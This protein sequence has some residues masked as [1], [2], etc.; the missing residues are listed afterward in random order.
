MGPTTIH[1]PLGGIF[2]THARDV[3]GPDGHISLIRTNVI[4]LRADAGAI[5]T[6]A[7]RLNVD[8]VYSAIAPAPI[9]FK[10]AQVSAPT[11]SIIAGPTSLF[12][13]ELVK[14]TTSGT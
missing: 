3:A 11:N 7:P 2:A 4:D 1:D 12:T 8:T 13:G 9:K 14:Y 10:T 5:G 6:A